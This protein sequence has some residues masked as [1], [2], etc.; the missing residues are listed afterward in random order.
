MPWTSA[1]AA[2]SLWKRHATCWTY[3]QEN[4]PQ[5]KWGNSSTLGTPTLFWTQKHQQTGKSPEERK[6][7]YKRSRK[8]S[9]KGLEEVHP[10]RIYTKLLEAQSPIEKFIFDGR[11]IPGWSG[12]QHSHTVQQSCQAVWEHLQLS[13]SLCGNW[14]V[15]SSSE[16]KCLWFL[17]QV[18]QTFSHFV[19][20][21]FCKVKEN[22]SYS[23]KL[24]NRMTI[25]HMKTLLKINL[26]NWS[27]YPVVTHGWWL[28]QNQWRLRKALLLCKRIEDTE[29]CFTWFDHWNHRSL[30]SNQDPKLIFFSSSLLLSPLPSIHIPTLVYPPVRVAV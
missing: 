17:S 19:R 30:W 27:Y 21:T 23:M 22:C 24:F 9:E 13:V 7:K 8:H 3:K 14:E 28:S 4:S 11:S 12:C 1:S 16:K 6:E 20:K 26:A 5:D 18:V 29:S 2:I 10:S 15:K 25:P